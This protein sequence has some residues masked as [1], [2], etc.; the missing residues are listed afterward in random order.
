VHIFIVALHRIAA[1][2]SAFVARMDCVAQESEY[3]TANGE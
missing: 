2:D 1:C 3:H